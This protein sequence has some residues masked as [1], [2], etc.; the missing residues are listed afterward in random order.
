MKLLALVGYS[1]AGKTGLIQK[2]IPEL[3]NRGNSVAVIKHCPHGF[4]LDR[5][6]HGFL[7]LH[8]GRF[9]GSRL[10]FPSE[11]GC[12]AG[13]GF[14]PHTA[15]IAETYFSDFDIVLVEGGKNEPGMPKIWV[16]AKWWKPASR[17]LER[18]DVI[19][20]I[21]EGHLDCPKPVFRAV[22]VRELA[23]FIL[24]YLMV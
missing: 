4:E 18:D 1:D 24:N 12:A 11:T 23:G 16:L 14:P 15:G 22:Q 2:L 20:L 19:A 3:N 7:A 6:R 13:E 10:A 5:R 8:A 21:A 9:S 17:R